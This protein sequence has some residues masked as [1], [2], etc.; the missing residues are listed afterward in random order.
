MVA[1][2]T[3]LI[4]AAPKSWKEILQHYHGQPYRTIYRAF[5]RLRGQLGRAGD[6][7]WFRYTFSDHD[8]SF[9]PP[10]AKLSNYDPRHG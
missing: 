8:F 9:E 7:P 10:P 6:D 3:A 4:K 1:D 5:G 2:M